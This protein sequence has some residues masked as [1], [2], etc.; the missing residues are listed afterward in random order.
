MPKDPICGMEGSIKAQGHDSCCDQGIKVF[1]KQ[2]KGKK[3]PWY[4]E[5]F[6]VVIY[7]SIFILTISYLFTPLFPVWEAFWDFF[8]M[9]WWAILL[10]LVIGAIIDYYIPQ[11]YITR[12][13]AGS[14]RTTI[15]NAALFGL[16][17]SAC[18]HGIL[19]IAI[20]LHKKGASIPAVVTFLLASPWANIPITI[21][22]FGFFGVKALLLVVSA[23]II[24]VITGFI[25]QFLEKRNL[26]EQS[27]KHTTKDFPFWQDVAK[28]WKSHTFNFK[29]DSKEL[30]RS[31]WSLNKMV[32]Y[33]ILIG[34][35]LAAFARAFVPTH[36]FHQYMGATF[37]GLVVT[38][39]IAT[40]IEVWKSA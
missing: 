38:L 17:M 29:K 5:K 23:L 37:L 4:L 16:I 36:F 25:Y 40:V 15:L 22:L 24:A 14:K 39:I 32:T 20:Q 1:E 19:A 10:G 26:I 27:P 31:M 8:K 13:L 35:I 11:E 7:L 18:C 28:R 2:I 9:I 3:Y 21:L 30:A 34:M 33:W 6:W 12:F